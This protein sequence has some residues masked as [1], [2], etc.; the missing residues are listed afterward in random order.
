MYI[1]VF[2]AFSELRFYT[3]NWIYNVTQS[4]QKNN[5]PSQTFD[6]LH[7][8]AHCPLGLRFFKLGPIKILPYQCSFSVPS[9]P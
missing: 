3:Y 4:Q 2:A 5:I 9:L 7:N 6:L 1:Y 8:L